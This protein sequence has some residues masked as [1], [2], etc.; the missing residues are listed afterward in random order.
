MLKLNKV[1]LFYGAFKALN[2]VSIHANQ[3]DLLS[4]W[5][6]MVLVKVLYS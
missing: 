3:G 4:C 1:D 6:P 2:E 5:V